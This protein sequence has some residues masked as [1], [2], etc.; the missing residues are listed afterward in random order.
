[1]HFKFS[2]DNL[3]RR[4]VAL[5]D[6]LVCLGGCGKEEFINH[7]FLECKF[8]SSNWLHIL[9]WLGICSVLSY[10]VCMHD[11][12]FGG[13]HLFQKYFNY[14]EGMKFSDFFATN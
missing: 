5:I 4:G 12:Q 14:L 10:D 11:L 7:I 13:S 2:K 9:Q 8:F 1:M 6:S 3:I